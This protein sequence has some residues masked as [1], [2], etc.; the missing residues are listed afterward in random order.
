MES[1]D[2][3]LKRLIL[4][5][6]PRMLIV[7]PAC[8]T[9][10]LPFLIK[11]TAESSF[12]V[13]MNIMVL[14]PLGFMIQRTFRRKL[15][16]NATKCSHL[17]ARF[18]PSLRLTGKQSSPPKYQELSIPNDPFSTEALGATKVRIY[19]LAIPMNT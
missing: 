13:L 16:G 15:P 6:K 11:T 18:F 5:L 3:K 2:S 12:S 8:M 14:L 7:Q 17:C 9:P 19:G 1:A 4:R 10:C